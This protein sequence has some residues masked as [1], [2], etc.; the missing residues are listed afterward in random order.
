MV[1]ETQRPEFIIILPGVVDLHNTQ[2]D[3]GLPECYYFGRRGWDPNMGVLHHQYGTTPP[4]REL[5]RSVERTFGGITTVEDIWVQ[6]D[7]HTRFVLRKNCTEEG[8]ARVREQVQEIFRAL[9]A[10]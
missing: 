1:A 10:E 5:V 3:C 8:V 4:S 6:T 9:L 2:E 7:G